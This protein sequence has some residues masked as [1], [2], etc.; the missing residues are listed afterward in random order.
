[1]LLIVLFSSTSGGPWPSLDQNI[2]FPPLTNPPRGLNKKASI[3]R[4]WIFGPVLC[5]VN[6]FV[7]LLSVSLSV[8]TLLAISLDRRTVSYSL[9]WYWPYTEQW[10]YF[11]DHRD[12]TCQVSSM[13]LLYRGILI[14]AICSY[15]IQKEGRHLCTDHDPRH[16]VNERSPGL[17][18]HRVLPG[19]HLWRVIKKKTQFK[20]NRSHCLLLLCVFKN[21]Y[22]HSSIHFLWTFIVEWTSQCVSLNGLTASREPPPMI[23]CKMKLCNFQSI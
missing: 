15:L 3:S 4:V 14:N 18:L 8:F 11:S 21:P 22:F 9:I 23:M 20:H 6:N 10:I 5:K 1:M 19:D 17:A 2:C 12:S 7:A 13:S 16:L